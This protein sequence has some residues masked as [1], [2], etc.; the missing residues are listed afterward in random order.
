MYTRAW[1]TDAAGN[2]KPVL[3]F[4]PVCVA[5]EHQRQG[6]GKALMEHSFEDEFPGARL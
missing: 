3:T 4:G 2:E 5:P 1:L 6:Y